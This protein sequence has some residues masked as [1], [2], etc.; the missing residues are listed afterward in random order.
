MTEKAEALEGA[1][2]GTARLFFWVWVALLVLTGV[3]TLLAYEELALLLFII[4]L[5]GISVVKS[6]LIMSYFMHLRFE[7]LGLFL[8]V[9]PTLVFLICL[10]LVFFYPDSVRLLEMRP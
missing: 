9:V 6:A 1:V 5:M 10:I 3:E 7:R 2:P 8:I 4:V